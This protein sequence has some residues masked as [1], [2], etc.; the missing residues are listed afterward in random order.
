MGL[1]WCQKTWGDKRMSHASGLPGTPSRRGHIPIYYQF[2]DMV[3]I[4]FPSCLSLHVFSSP[5]CKHLLALL[6]SALGALALVTF[7]LIRY[8]V[9]FSQEFT[10]FYLLLSQPARYRLTS[11]ADYVFVSVR[12]PK[13]LWTTLCVDS[14]SW[15]FWIPRV[16]LGCW[17]YLEWFWMCQDVKVPWYVCVRSEENSKVRS[18]GQFYSLPSDWTEVVR[19]HHLYLLT[20]WD[21]PL[22]GPFLVLL[23]SENCGSPLCMRGT[24]NMDTPQGLLVLYSCKWLGK[25]IHGSG[26]VHS[27]AKALRA[28]WA[29][30]QFSDLPMVGKPLGPSQ[31]SAD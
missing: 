26:L 9:F 13:T 25:W 31:R 3:G 12:S 16:T 30:G 14:L 18:G 24:M 27:C 23:Y 22:A 28:Q 5:S 4:V 8:V 20:Y 2:W 6:S 19:L 7:P 21:S 29:D 10:H 1:S 11:M 17:S 15:R